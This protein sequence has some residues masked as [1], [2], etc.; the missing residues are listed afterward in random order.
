VHGDQVVA[1]D[2]L[3]QLDV[4]HMPTLPDLGRMQH[5]EH[6]IG[7][8]VDLGNVV[9]LGAIAHRDAVKSDDFRQRLDGGLVAGRDVDPHDDVLPLEQPG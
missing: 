3:V 6:V 5:S 9:A 2:K 1:A 4:V 8:D 7:I